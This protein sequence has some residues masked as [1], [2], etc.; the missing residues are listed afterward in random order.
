MHIF[1]TSVLLWTMKSLHIGNSDVLYNPECILWHYK[2]ATPYILGSSFNA[3]PSI[4]Q[5]K[6]HFSKFFHL[7]AHNNLHFQTLLYKICLH[8]AEQEHITCPL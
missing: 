5:E 2:F 8:L 7:S 3:N 6:T 1:N 4:I